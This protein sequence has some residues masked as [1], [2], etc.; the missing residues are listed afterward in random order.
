MACGTKTSVVEIRCLSPFLRR[1]PLSRRERVGVRG[2]ISMVHWWRHDRL[3]PFFR[4][5]YKDCWK[6]IGSP[7]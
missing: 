7:F 2:C 5:L 3:S 4:E 6:K 1:F